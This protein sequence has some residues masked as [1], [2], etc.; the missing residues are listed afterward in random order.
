MKVRAGFVSNSSSSSFIL[1]S[2]TYDTVFDAAIEMLNIRTEDGWPECPEIPLIKKA[3]SLG[4]DQDTAVRFSTC[5]YETYI[6]KEERTKEIYVS[7]CTNHPFYN[8]L[9]F[10]HSGGGADEGDFSK[11]IENTYFWHI[12]SDTFGKDVTREEFKKFKHNNPE[13]FV[14]DHSNWPHCWIVTNDGHRK[15]WSELI[16]T[17]DN[18]IICPE[19]FIENK[20]QG[21]LLALKNYK[22]IV[23]PTKKKVKLR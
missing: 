22:G 10:I 2:N 9:D 8:Q 6:F 19:C 17:P 5:N 1:N 18:R 20:E 13:L 12:L 23:A 11:E 21:M 3:I 14:N 16:I 15:H 4:V 7:T